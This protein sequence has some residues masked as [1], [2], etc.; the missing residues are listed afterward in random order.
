MFRMVLEY[1]EFWNTE[2]LSNLPKKSV[3]VCVGGG[4]G[5]GGD[6]PPKIYRPTSIFCLQECVVPHTFSM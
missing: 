6:R 3:C 5:G 1:E 2:C 4:G